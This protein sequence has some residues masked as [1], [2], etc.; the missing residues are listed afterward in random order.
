MSDQV[1]LLSGG[2]PRINRITIDQPWDWLA[3]GWAD[4]RAAPAVGFGYGALFVAAGFVAL[5]L[6]WV[7][8]IFALFLPLAGGFLLVAPVLAVGLYET[9]RRLAAGEPT[10]MRLALTA[11][12]RNLGQVA[13]LGVALLLFFI[14]WMR[15]ASLIFMLFFA[16]DPPAPDSFIQHV[17]FRWD[18][19]PFLLVGCGIGAVLATLVFAITVV[20]VPM[21]L[22]RD[23]NVVVAIATSVE[24]VRQNPFPMFVWACLIVLFTGAGLATG[25]LGLIITLPIVGHASWHAYR[26][27]VAPATASEAAAL[28][29][30]ESLA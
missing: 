4:L 22:D 11:W 5:A 20:S 13:L 17:F 27:L 25:Y 26:D 12:R 24:A 28:S 18:S 23:V 1:P 6:M 10:S 29:G 16:Y 7:W 2:V 21:L 9:S 8:D 30:R 3:A 15:L 14:A 19:I